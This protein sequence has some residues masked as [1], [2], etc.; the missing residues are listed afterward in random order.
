[1]TNL[2]DFIQSTLYG[3]FPHPD[4]TG[5]YGNSHVIYFVIYTQIVLLTLLISFFKPLQ[6]YFDPFLICFYHGWRNYFFSLFIFFFLLIS[7][8]QI[9]MHVRYFSNRYTRLVSF[10]PGYFNNSTRIKNFANGCQQFF[11]K[12]RLKGK[13]I[14]DLD[15]TDDPGMIMHKNLRTKLTR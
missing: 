13:L 1:M 6:K 5:F 15:I 4:I 14:T 11:G 7:F 9:S 2:F 10:G 8:T 12:E 3:I